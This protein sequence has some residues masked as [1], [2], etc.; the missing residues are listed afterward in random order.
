M[1]GFLFACIQ[2]TRQCQS[3]EIAVLKTRTSRNSD[4]AGE[5]RNGCRQSLTHFAVP[6]NSV[7]TVMGNWHLESYGMTKKWPF[8]VQY[9][10]LL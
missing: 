8:C 5:K 10:D 7:V 9:C 4:A 6:V 3:I 1:F 2:M